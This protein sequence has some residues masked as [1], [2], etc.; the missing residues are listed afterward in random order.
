MET[1]TDSSKRKHLIAATLWIAVGEAA[2]FLPFFWPTGPVTARTVLGLL[3]FLAVC[4]AGGFL[5]AVLT[6]KPLSKWLNH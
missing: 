2:V 4:V 5:F 3:L 1:K 6:W